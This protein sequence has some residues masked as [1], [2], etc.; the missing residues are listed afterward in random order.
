[1]DGKAFLSFWF[2]IYGTTLTVHTRWNLL[3]IV[4]VQHIFH[5]S[6][7]K[8]FSIFAIASHNHSPG[9]NWTL[10]PMQSRC[11]KYCILCYELICLFWGDFYHRVFPYIVTQSGWLK[12]VS[13]VIDPLKKKKKKNS[14]QY[15]NSKL[16]EIKH[17]QNIKIPYFYSFLCTHK[18]I[19]PLAWTST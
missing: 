4:F 15:H 1:M 12:L 2:V 16:W 6:R 8:L 19:L 18:T 13:F 3:H 11:T 5:C 9:Q 10:T 14:D 17:I 7:I